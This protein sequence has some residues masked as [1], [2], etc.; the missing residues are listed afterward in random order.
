MMLLHSGFFNTEF[1]DFLVIGW[2]H[3]ID[4]KAYDHL[5]FI[6]VLCAS[7]T[8][9]DWKKVLAVITAFTIGHSFT[10]ALSALNYFFI[11][12]NTVEILIPLTIVATAITNIIRKEPEQEKTFDSRLI[13]SYGIAMCF[14]LIHGLGFANNFRFFLGEES[15]I[16]AQLFAFNSGLELG[17]IM[18]VL[19]F[20]FLLWLFT[21]LFNMVHR[22]WTVFISGAGAGISLIMI[23]DNL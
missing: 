11:A 18:V 20:M 1:V 7:F 9:K 5:L 22:D 2:D 3:I 14:G 23:L 12:P 13:L 6:M 15:S 8:L 10:L 16:I 21:K 19:C 17:Q 4:V